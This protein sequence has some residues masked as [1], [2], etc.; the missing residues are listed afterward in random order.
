MEFKI[1]MKFCG[2]WLRG[3]V[4]VIG[5]DSENNILNVEIHNVNIN[6]YTEE[7]NLQH[8]IWGFENKEYRLLE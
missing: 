1:G 2:K 7:W 4:E 6:S 8:T 5:I 3:E